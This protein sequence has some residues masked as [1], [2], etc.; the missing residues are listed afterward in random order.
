MN[1]LQTQQCLKNQNKIMRIY[2]Y[3][4]YR[5]YQPLLI[6]YGSNKKT[7]NYLLTTTSTLFV[8]F[9][10]VVI[11]SFL[12][13]Y[14]FKIYDKILPNTTSVVVSA[15]I[16]G[17][18]NYWFFIRKK[19]ILDYNFTQD[20]KGG[21]LL[22][23]YILFIGVLAVHFANKNREKIIKEKKLKNVTTLVVCPIT[24]YPNFKT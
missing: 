2:Y 17:F 4:L 8:Y 14:F 19:K 10:F 3:L 5:I 9:T 6:G 15:I 13:F 1:I 7:V 11:L 12:D 21:Y 24:A 16:I 20:K 23:L 18:F 22:F